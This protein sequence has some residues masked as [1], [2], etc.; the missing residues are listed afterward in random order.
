MFT[1]TDTPVKF[2]GLL[3]LFTFT[4]LWSVYQLA[5][6]QSRPTLVSNLAHLLMSVVMLLMVPST[7]WRPF[8]A[9]VPL[10]VLVGVFG[11]FALW[12]GWL[13]VRGLGAGNT[14][15][16]HGWHALGHAGMFGAMTW[17]L[18]AMLGHSA[19]AA[20]PPSDAD[21]TAVSSETMGHGTVGH[22]T[23]GHGTMGHSPQGS[24]TELMSMQVAGPG[25]AA[26]LVAIV[27]VPFMTYLLA[28]ALWNLKSAIAPSASIRDR[29]GHEAAGHG[30]YAA[31]NPRV[32]ALADFAMNFG[33]FWMSTGLMVALLPVLRHLSF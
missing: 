1:L 24:T 12:F 17:H 21:S 29:A 20:H 2:V 31:G 5:R 16:R 33:M 26:V 13:G 22:S 30:H 4:T 32:A 11:M 14:L 23:M 28:A 19:G 27:G 3:I 10:P 9:V 6:R 15:R 25:G 7:L 18:A 8:G